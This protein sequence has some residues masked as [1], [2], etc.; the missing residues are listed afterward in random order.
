MSWGIWGKGG[1]GVEGGTEFLPSSSV[2]VGINIL[3]AEPTCNEYS[4]VSHSVTDQHFTSPNLHTSGSGLVLLKLV[5]RSVTNT[6]ASLNHRCCLV[7]D[8]YK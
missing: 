2:E 3:G 6:R 8:K 7:L 5:K 1:G 4:Y